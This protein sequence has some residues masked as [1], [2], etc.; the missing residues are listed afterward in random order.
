MHAWSLLNGIADIRIPARKAAVLFPSSNF[1][2]ACSR[3]LP[4]IDEAPRRADRGDMSGNPGT[5]DSDRDYTV[6]IPSD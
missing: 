4:A 2:S 1:A 5:V 3:L 6:A